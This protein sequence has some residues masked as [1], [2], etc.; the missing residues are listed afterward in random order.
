[1]GIYTLNDNLNFGN[2]L[3]NYAVQYILSPYGKVENMTY[4]YKS[5]NER[6][7]YYLW[8]FSWGYI[9]KI[10]PRKTYRSYRFID[11]NRNMSYKKY[12][13]DNYDMFFYGSDQIWN[14][15]YADSFMIC[16]KT[17]PE[18]NIAL[19]ASMGIDTIPEKYNKLFSDG[20]TRFRVVSVREKRASEL[21]E[22]YTGKKPEILIDPT[23]YVPVSQ[24]RLLEK[25]PVG[26]VP[27]KYILIY[28]LGDL[29]DKRKKQIESFAK[30]KQIEIIDLR[31]KAN[32]DHVGPAEFLYLLDHAEL[33]ITDSF[34]GSVFSILFD[35]TLTILSREDKQKSMASRIETLMETFE[36]KKQVITDIDHLSLEHDYSKA[37]I[38]LDYERKRVDTFLQHI[39]RT[40]DE[41]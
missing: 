26:K 31:T 40:K 11:F 10:F 30:S 38:Q 27:S 9:E 34:H 13:N 12:K 1:M 15:F 39:M 20:L 4:R 24:W 41:N 28:F 8:K 36:L 22:H 32:W 2:R 37:Y 33:V 16:P 29:S 6:I 21:V 5:V 35:K 17:K 18:Q 23:M 25:K 7:K 14:P 3:Q 19:C